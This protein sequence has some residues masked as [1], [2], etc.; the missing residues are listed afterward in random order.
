ML[1]QMDKKSNGA[2]GKALAILE[3]I[4]EDARPIAVPDIVDANIPI[5]Y[6]GEPADVA[7]L[8]AYLSSSQAGYIT[9]AVIP[10]DGGMHYY[11][12]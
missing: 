8:V 10:V 3:A 2:L 9:G 1:K 11:G 6:F 5:G 7:N 12:H 4:A